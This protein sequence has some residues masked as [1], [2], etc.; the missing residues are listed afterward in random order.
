MC[1]KFY[2]TIVEGQRCFSLDVAKLDLNPTESGKNNGLFVL[3]DSDPYQLNSNDKSVERETSKVYI[4]TLTH[5]TSNTPGS[6]ALSGLKKMTG[7]S[8]FKKLPDRK[9]V[10]QDHNREECQAK[11]YLERVK[12]EC[13]CLPWAL[14]SGQQEYQVKNR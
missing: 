1:D 2:P 10:C 9:K 3:L 4:H 12:R 5:F 8:S 7:T 11:S 14:E 13:N 6:F